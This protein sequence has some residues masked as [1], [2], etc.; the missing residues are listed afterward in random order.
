MRE[1][2]TFQICSDWWLISYPTADWLDGNGH[3]TLPDFTMAPLNK[4]QCS[5]QWI[6]APKLGDNS[7]IVYSMAFHAVLWLVSMSVK[8]RFTFLDFSGVVFDHY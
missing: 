3:W 7:V 5:S 1:C 2:V 6:K 8:Y 4:Y